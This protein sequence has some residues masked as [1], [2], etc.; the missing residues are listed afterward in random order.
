[1]IIAQ[2]YSAEKNVPMWHTDPPKVEVYINHAAFCA[3][4]RQCFYDDPGAHTYGFVDFFRQTVVLSD[5]DNEVLY[6]ELG[7]WYFDYAEEGAKDF[8]EFER[9][10]K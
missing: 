10:H 3:R 4:Y 9:W 2:E 6:H 1:L 7:H 8:A 5:W